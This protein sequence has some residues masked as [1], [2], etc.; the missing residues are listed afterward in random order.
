MLRFVY[1]VPDTIISRFSITYFSDVSIQFS[2]C[3][4]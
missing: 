4:Q 3:I 1:N 2:I